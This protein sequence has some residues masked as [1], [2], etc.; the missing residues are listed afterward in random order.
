MYQAELRGK[1]SPGIENKEDI[2]TSNVFSF[3]KYSS[4]DIFL[5][6]YLK[7]LDL[8][9]SEKEAEEAEFM[10]W[11]RYDDDT[12][13][14]LVI[15]VAGYYLLIEAKY[16]SD[17]GKETPKTKAQLVREI[18]GGKQEA[19]NFGK[20]FLLITITADSCKDEYKL[21]DI[22]AD[23]RDECIWT[24]WQ[25]VSWIISDILNGTLKLRKEEQDF[26][27]D[28]YLLLDKKHL[29]GYRGWD[30]LQPYKTK[31]KKSLFIFFDPRTAKFRGDF[32]GF[33]NALSV[34]KK[35]HRFVKPLFFGTGRNY[36][37]QTLPE[38]KI[39][40]I[41]SPLFFKRGLSIDEQR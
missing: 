24:N 7:T 36:F 26:A 41:G 13:P 29:R 28:L 22:P 1:L 33:D 39:T 18:I 5:K 16:F 35:I 23:S 3:F 19:K 11:P 2:L 21:R 30:P 14:D 9:V 38:K 32:I 10:F 20:E 31:A 4:R 15:L 6:A 12:E 8:E 25:R 37:T 27:I 40:G 17:F 34:D